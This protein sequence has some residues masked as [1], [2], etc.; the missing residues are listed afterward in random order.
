MF[1]TASKINAM[2]GLMRQSPGTLNV[3]LMTRLKMISMTGCSVVAAHKE[4]PETEE[5]TG[6]LRDSH[7]LT[8]AVTSILIVSF[9]NYRK[10]LIRAAALLILI[11]IQMKIDHRKKEDKKRKRK[12]SLL[13][14]IFV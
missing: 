14:K 11:L 5:M 13:N 7:H 6:N 12:E 4:V 10:V 8:I 3:Q 2:I 1:M 9:K